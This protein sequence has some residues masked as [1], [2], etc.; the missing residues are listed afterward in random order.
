MIA[1]ICLEVD[2]EGR[3]ELEKSALDWIPDEVGSGLESV[4]AEGL[5]NVILKLPL[6]LER[7][8]RNVGVGTE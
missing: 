4:L 8:L 3:A 5:G 7:L 1:G 6:A 2:F